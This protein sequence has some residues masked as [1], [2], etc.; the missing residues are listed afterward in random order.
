MATV[1][2]ELRRPESIMLETLPKIL[3]EI[4]QKFPLLC[5]NSFL[6]CSNMLTVITAVSYVYTNN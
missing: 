2:L 4:S 6:L 3:L 1:L 5:L